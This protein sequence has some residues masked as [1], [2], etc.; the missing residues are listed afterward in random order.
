VDEDRQLPPPTSIPLP[1]TA[2][3]TILP[4]RTIDG[5]VQADVQV[6]SIGVEGGRHLLLGGNAGVHALLRLHVEC[7]TALREFTALNSSGDAGLRMC[8]RRGEG[9]GNV[10]T[11]IT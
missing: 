5:L 6:G 3:T 4:P 9:E 10:I 7:H 11:M 2:T 8:A 1:A